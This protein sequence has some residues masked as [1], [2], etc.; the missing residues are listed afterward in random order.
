LHTAH[1][2]TW[3]AAGVKLLQVY[4]EVVAGNS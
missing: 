2:I 1:E 4:R 3:A